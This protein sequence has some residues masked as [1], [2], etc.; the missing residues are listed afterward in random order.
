MVL[1]KVKDQ[2]TSRGNWRNTLHIFFQ[3]HGA[4]V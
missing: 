2:D 3:R 4:G 1:F